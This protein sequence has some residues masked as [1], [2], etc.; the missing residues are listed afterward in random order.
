MEFNSSHDPG[1]FVPVLACPLLDNRTLKR[2]IR[3]SMND[4]FVKSMKRLFSVIPAPYQ[5]RDK[6]Q[7]E[8]SLFNYLELPWIPVFT[9]MTIFYEFIMNEGSGNKKNGL[10][11]FPGRFL[12]R[13]N[14]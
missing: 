9:G 7:Q 5:V 4:G 10:E 14:S 13:F 12:T 8:S 3:F 1:R 11:G 6:L 2:F